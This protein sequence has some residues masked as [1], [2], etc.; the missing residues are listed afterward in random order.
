MYVATFV[1]GR[2]GGFAKRNASEQFTISTISSFEY[3]LSVGIGS[4][5]GVDVSWDIS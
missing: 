1:I 4:G 5:R 2:Y 3:D